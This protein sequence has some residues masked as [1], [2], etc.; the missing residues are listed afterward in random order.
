MSELARHLLGGV[1]QLVYGHSEFGLRCAVQPP[2]HNVFAALCETYLGESPSCD[3]PG[4]PDQNNKHMTRCLSVRRDP[5]EE[6]RVPRLT[7]SPHRL[8]WVPELPVVEKAAALALAAPS[9]SPHPAAQ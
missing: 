1:Q 6:P 4:L 8:V 2:T 3:T 7:V 9:L 5:G